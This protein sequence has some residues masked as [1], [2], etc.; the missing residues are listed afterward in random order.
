VAEQ[1]AAPIALEIDD[2][3]FDRHWIARR[4]CCGAAVT[5]MADRRPSS[6]RPC[7]LER[8]ART[9]E[10]GRPVCSNFVPPLARSLSGTVSLPSTGKTIRLPEG[11]RFWT[12]YRV[13]RASRIMTCH[14]RGMDTYKIDLNA[15]GWF[16]VTVTAPNGDSRVRHPFANER[17]AQK[18]VDKCQQNG[19][20][21]APLVS[22]ARAA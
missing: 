13:I 15:H 16:Q 8:N 2:L 3:A 17:A 5:L 11:R 18:W 19:A 14:I 1:R 7:R 4:S 10:P 12:S 21:V 9:S 20:K 22:P 6:S